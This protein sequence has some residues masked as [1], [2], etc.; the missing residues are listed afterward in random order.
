MNFKTKFKTPFWSS[1]GYNVANPRD[2]LLLLGNE[3]LETPMAWRC[4]YF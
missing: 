1:R 3:I 2:G 4:R